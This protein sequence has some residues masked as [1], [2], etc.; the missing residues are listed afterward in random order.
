MLKKFSARFF[1]SIALIFAAL[2]IAVS[3][4]ARLMSLRQG[5]Q[6]RE[7]QPLV[8]HVEGYRVESFRLRERVHAFGTAQ[9][10]R[11]TVLSAEVAGKV[12]WTNA[13]FKVGQEM[14]AAAYPTTAE[15][16]GN[17]APSVAAGDM[18]LKIDPATYADRVSQ[19][20]ERL[21][22][23]I[24][25]RARLAQEQANSAKL[26][27]IATDD[28]NEFFKDY[29]RRLE[30]V[31]MGV[32]TEA[33]RS[34]L[35]LDLQVYER[36]KV[37]AE[38]E[39]AL[40]PIRLRQLEQQV[41]Q[42]GVEKRMADE[43]LRRAVIRPP[44]TGFLSE[45]RVEVGT[46]L[47]V[48]D[49]VARIVDLSK[50]VIPV[51]VTLHDYHKLKPQLDS[52]QRPVVELA[53]HS[54]DES[55]WTGEVVRIAPEADQRTRTIEV[56]I[57]VDNR[58]QAVPLL[59][60]TFVHARIAGPLHASQDVVAIPRDAHRGTQV[61]VMEDGLARQREIAVRESLQSMTLVE[62]G[63]KP[64]DVL[65]LTNLDVIVDGDRVEAGE[66][67]ERIRD[68][69]GEMS[70]QDPRRLNLQIEAGP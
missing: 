51:S 19:I 23:A 24:V 22:E 29:Q 52:G 57:E 68:L 56:F 30:L 16:E 35:K 50:V 9:A 46:Y 11:E 53:L 61:F 27:K 54:E 41:R 36:A 25:E 2:F 32:K 43:D 3:G 66:D 67:G 8:Y 6:P 58:A 39:H 26:L 60:G 45:V 37:Q 65:V 62:S 13:R 40:I 12:V 63:L 48:G 14:Q 69:P 10:D 1:L 5:P 42:L 70:R 34:R 33:E 59:P 55:Q 49:P 31:G 15:E 21:A 17:G 18:L 7:E 38:N 28:Y 20:E 64:G 47:R 44:F 4:F